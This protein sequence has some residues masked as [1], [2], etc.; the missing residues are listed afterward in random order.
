MCETRE[1]WRGHSR[2]SPVCARPERYGVVTVECHQ[3]VRETRE[4]WSGHSRVSPV[5]AR[6]ERHGVV[7]VECHQYVRDQRD[8]EW[9]Q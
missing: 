9:S 5:C 7:T 1:I 8:M 2:V 3:C 6:P 4:T